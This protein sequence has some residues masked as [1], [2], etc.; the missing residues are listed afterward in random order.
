MELNP[1]PGWP[2]VKP[3][4]AQRAAPRSE[5]RV[6]RAAAFHAS[7]EAS[8]VGLGPQSSFSLSV[9]THLRASHDV[10]EAKGKG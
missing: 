7:E 10:E 8:S 2:K 6:R 3:M 1:G 9:F 4:Q 5:R